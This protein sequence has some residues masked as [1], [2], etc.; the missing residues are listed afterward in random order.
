M[1][2][3]PYSE[4]K[5]RSRDDGCVA[6]WGGGV[7]FRDGEFVFWCNERDGS[8]ALSL[9]SINECSFVPLVPSRLR[10]SYCSGT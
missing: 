10:Q 4:L 6:R 1:V 9:L 8:H 2:T 3:M 7:C 5:K